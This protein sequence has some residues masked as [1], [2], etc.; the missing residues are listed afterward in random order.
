[1]PPPHV[2]ELYTLN[3]PHECVPRMPATDSVQNVE[4]YDQR[5]IKSKC[6]VT[7]V[8]SDEPLTTWSMMLGAWACIMHGRAWGT[9]PRGHAAARRPAVVNVIGLGL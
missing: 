2:S 3:K 7:P 5:T 8:G 9:H 4:R 1:M 6:N